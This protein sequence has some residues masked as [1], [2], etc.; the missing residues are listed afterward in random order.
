MAEYNLEVFQDGGVYVKDY[1]QECNLSAAFTSLS[2]NNSVADALSG[3]SWSERI[4]HSVYLVDGK[5]VNLRNEIRVE[6]TTSA[7]SA[8]VIEEFEYM[9]GDID[10][11][12]T[13][14]YNLAGNAK[15]YVTGDLAMLQTVL[16]GLSSSQV[17]ST[18][19]SLSVSFLVLFLLTRRIMPAIVILFPVG[20]ASLWVVGSMAAIGLKWNV[21]T[22]MVTALTLGIGI[23]YSIHMWRRFE[24]ELRRKRKPLGCTQSLYI[25][26]W[27]SFVNERF[28]NF[29]WFHGVIILSDANYPRFRTY[30]CNN[31]DFLLGSISGSLTSINGIVC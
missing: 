19:I 6:A 30:H 14:R 21:L 22:V 24:V 17:E 1:N 18:L 2:Q 12:G 15:L 25:N 5:V 29:S 9:L 4:K 8:Q 27:R 16:D 26:N 28:D 31:S 11:S 13:L 20:I 23:D 7:E 3:E 10:K